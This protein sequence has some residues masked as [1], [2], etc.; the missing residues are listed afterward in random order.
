MA[1]SKMHPVQIGRRG[2]EGNLSV[3]C[4]EN[5]VPAGINRQPSFLSELT[6]QPSD[7]Y[8]CGPNRVG[9]LLVGEANRE[10]CSMSHWTSYLLL[11]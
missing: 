5:N 10:P 3:G 11:E 7:R 4:M 1:G 9:E 8:P 2:P 6:Q